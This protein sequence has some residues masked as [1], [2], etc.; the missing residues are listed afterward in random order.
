MLVRKHRAVYCFTRFM[1][2]DIR[3]MRF[4]SRQ[5]PHDTWTMCTKH[6]TRGDGC[7]LHFHFRLA[8]WRLIGDLIYAITCCVFMCD[9]ISAHKQ[10][11][12]WQTGCGD[13]NI[14]SWTQ[15]SPGRHSRVR[16]FARMQCTQRA[17][18]FT[19][20]IVRAACENI[21]TNTH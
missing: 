13:Y 3:Q 8:R 21:Q 12:C 7:C 6:T 20:G 14:G 1:R 11:E 18:I 17:Q 19:L 9:N 2:T 16:L 10:F 4:L 15:W 5:R